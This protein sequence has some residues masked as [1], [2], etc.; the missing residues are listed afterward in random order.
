M[1]LFDA[2][3]IILI[4]I[5]LSAAIGATSTY[6]MGP[7][8]EVEEFCEDVIDIV[9]GG[10]IDLSPEHYDDLDGITELDEDEI[11]EILRERNRL[12]EL[13]STSST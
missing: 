1:Y 3:T 10:D 12:E 8:N 7:D 11:I 13:N 4:I 5:A 6:F 2:S 9:G